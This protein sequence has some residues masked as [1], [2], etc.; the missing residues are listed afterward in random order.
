PR[1][2]GLTLRAAG[3]L[4]L[5]GNLSDGFS[6]P[7][8]SG[9]LLSTQSWDLR[10]IGGADL[11]SAGMLATAPIAGLPTGSGSVGVGRAAAGKLV[12]T[13]TGDLA[14]RAGRDV[15][16]ANYASAVYTAGRKDTTPLAN[17][18]APSAAAYGI[19]G[20]NLSIVAGGS[21]AAPTEAAS[22][23]N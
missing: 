2:G 16:F 20:G 4:V 6:S 1:Q 3:N 14:I 17:F 7:L 5:T 13:G 21:I 19:D 15:Q 8:T 9:T 23:T 11:S 18:T 10:L 12:R 22:S